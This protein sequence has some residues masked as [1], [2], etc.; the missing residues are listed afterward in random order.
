MNTPDQSR[1]NFV[2]SQMNLYPFPGLSSLAK[3][4]RKP[5]GERFWQ[6]Q[7]QHHICIGFPGHFIIFMSGKKLMCQNIGHIQKNLIQVLAGVDGFI[8]RN[9]NNIVVDKTHHDTPLVINE[10][11][12]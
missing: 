1:N 6:G 9:V 11:I 12:D 5:V 2:L 10:C 3:L 7:R 8:E 4:R